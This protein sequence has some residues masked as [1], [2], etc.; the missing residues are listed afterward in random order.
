M[1]N[2]KITDLLRKIKYEL[3]FEYHDATFENSQLSLFYCTRH[4]WQKRQEKKMLQK[5]DKAHM[6]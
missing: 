2:I 4:D 3:D 5:F 1:T 6:D